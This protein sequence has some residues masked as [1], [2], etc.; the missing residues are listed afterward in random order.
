VYVSRAQVYAFLISETDKRGAEASA[1]RVACTDAALESA[2]DALEVCAR[3]DSDEYRYIV[4]A[5]G[6]I[7]AHEQDTRAAGSGRSSTGLLQVLEVLGTQ[8]QES[9]AQRLEI[10]KLTARGEACLDAA[11]AADAAEAAGAGPSRGSAL[12]SRPLLPRAQARIRRGVARKRVRGA[13]CPHRRR[14][15]GEESGRR[16]TGGSGRPEASRSGDPNADRSGRPTAAVGR[17]R[18]Q[19]ATPTP[20][21]PHEGRRRSPSA[22]A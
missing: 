15:E 20:P 19:K 5:V 1:V 12:L 6:R 17:L 7:M 10:D 13:C 16:S 11:R 8:R 18:E 21:S 14:E 9:V 22:A 4:G 2:R 3:L